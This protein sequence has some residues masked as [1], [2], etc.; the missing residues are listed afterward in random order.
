MDPRQFSLNKKGTKA[1]VGLQD[2]GR[3]VVKEREGDGTYG[4]FV[5]HANVAGQVTCVIW[6]EGEPVVEDE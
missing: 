1:A 6:A 4:D 2:D 3:V 5:A